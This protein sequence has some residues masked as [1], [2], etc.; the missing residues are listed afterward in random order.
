MT[1]S[2][3]ARYVRHQPDHPQLA[4]A[5]ERRTNPGATRKLGIIGGAPTYNLSLACTKVSILLFYLRFPAS[6]AFKAATFLVMFLAVGNGL[7][8]ATAVLYLCRPIA[9]YW[10][11]SVGGVCS[12]SVVPFWVTAIVNMSTDVFILLLPLW[13]IMPLRLPPL[14]KIGVACALI[15]GGL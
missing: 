14:R 13:L 6:R 5:D 11:K 2:R 12:G 9:A 10:D 15:P 1:L 4:T 7:S 8:A 3:L